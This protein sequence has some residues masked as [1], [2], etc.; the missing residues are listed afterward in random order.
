LR[1]LKVVSFLRGQRVDVNRPTR[2]EAPDARVKELGGLG[3][4]ERQR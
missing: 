3:P 1:D 4:G 2:V